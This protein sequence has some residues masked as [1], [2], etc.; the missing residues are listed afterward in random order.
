MKTP[1][2]WLPLLALALLALA[3]LA[4]CSARP[5]MAAEYDDDASGTVPR[6]IV[7]ENRFAIVAQ[8]DTTQAY[9]R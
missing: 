4:G 6:D 7:K 1:R 3:L 8:T 5:Q 9:N 2:P